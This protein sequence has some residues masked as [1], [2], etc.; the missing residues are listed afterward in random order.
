MSERSQRISEFQR[1][2][3]ARAEDRL[4]WA[5]SSEARSTAGLLVTECRR[6]VQEIAYVQQ[7]NDSPELA[8]QR[9][10]AQ[11][12]LDAARDLCR[13]MGGTEVE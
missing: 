3:R 12:H 2:H 9:V 1:Q 8:A 10:Q 6:A 11:A 13:R 7:W 5:A 4:R